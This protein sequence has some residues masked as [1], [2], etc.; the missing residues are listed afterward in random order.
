MAKYSFLPTWYF[1]ESKLPWIREVLNFWHKK[2][3]LRLVAEI[4]NYVSDKKLVLIPYLERFPN[5]ISRFFIILFITHCLFPIYRDSLIAKIWCKNFPYNSSH[6]MKKQ[7]SL[8]CKHFLKSE[9]VIRTCTENRSCIVHKSLN[10]SFFLERNYQSSDIVTPE[11]PFFV[12][13]WRGKY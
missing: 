9:V 4:I 3:G 12:V 11:I 13:I 8:F 7:C 5:E 6:K 2:V 1:W 10:Y